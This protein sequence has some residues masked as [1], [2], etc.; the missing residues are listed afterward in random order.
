MPITHRLIP[1]IGCIMLCLALYSSCERIELDNKATNKPQ[2]RPD[3]PSISPQ[4][5]TYNISAAQQLLG[6]EVLVIGYIV[7][8]I[9]GT[10]IS[11]ATF[12]PPFTSQSNL[13]LADDPTSTEPAQCLPIALPA[14]SNIR[15]ELNLK[16]NPTLHRKRV[17]IL[18][19]ITPYFQR[20]GIRQ[21]QAYELLEDKE[22]DP[23]PPTLPRDTAHNISYP[24]LD[25]TYTDT[26]IS[27]TG[28][29]SSVR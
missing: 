1:Y 27:R 29:L 15:H 21:P 7:G 19:T 20:P 14:A 24:T 26:L 25:S 3:T 17:I 9:E 28:S 16:T 8:C 11:K 12:T 10:S 4:Q 23:T 13:I 2:H 18:G 5:H 6:Q 22:I